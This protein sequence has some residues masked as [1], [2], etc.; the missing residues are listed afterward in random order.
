MVESDWWRIEGE[1]S[2]GM[3]DRTKRQLEEGR[4]GNG[5]VLKCRNR[6]PAGPEEPGGSQAR[7][8][9]RS[10]KPAAGGQAHWDLLSA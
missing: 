2:I 5:E 9:T 6:N 10:R 8:C 3:L 4:A 1:R 7:L